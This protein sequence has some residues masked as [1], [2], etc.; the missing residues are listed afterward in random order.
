MTDSALTDEQLGR[1]ALGGDRDAFT[2][3]FGRYEPGLYNVVYRVTGNRE[4]AADITQEAFLRVYARLD[5][6][7]GR[8]IN[9]GAYLHR[10]ARNLVYDHGST[11][12][13][14]RP[15]A[16]I[17]RDAG[18]DPSPTADPALSI[19][20]AAQGDDVRAANARLPERHRL[21]LALRELEGMSYAEIG[22]VLDITTGAVAQ[23]VARARLALRRELRI[24]QVDPETMDPACRARLGYI[25][26]LLDGELPVDRAH[27]L[28]QHI[29]LCPTCTASRAAFEDASV[30]YR[31]WLPLPIVG[32][33]LGASTARAADARDPGQVTASQLP[34][35]PPEETVAALMPPMRGGRVAVAVGAFTLLALLVAMAVLVGIRSGSDAAPPPPGVTEVAGVPVVDAAPPAATTR[36]TRTGAAAT[37]TG[38]TTDQGTPAAPAAG[39]SSTP[40][41][42]GSTVATSP[43]GRGSVAPVGTPTRGAGTTAPGAAPPASVAT[44]AQPAGGGSTASPPA[45]GT[46]P[47]T[48]GAAPATTTQTTTQPTTQTTTPPTTQPT[49]QPTQPTTGAPPTTTDAPTTPTGTA[50]AF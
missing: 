32:L 11:R 33:G 13:R 8:E 9:L 41:R 19:L 3:L 34:P 35:E 4:D 43:P 23:L 16:T 28:S 39:G 22:R 38:T 10:T 1:R 36:A 24:A 7:R 26:M 2:E 17:E 46:R 44:G 45:A 48:T 25:G 30:R 40:G 21:V 29:S 5:D 49:T 15:S 31:A 50:P 12:A 42:G 27:A 37:T 47:T 6:L 18:A 20:A 14:E